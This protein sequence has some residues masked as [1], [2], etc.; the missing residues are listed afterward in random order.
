MNTRVGHSGRGA[1]TEGGETGRTGGKAKGRAQGGVRSD[2]GQRAGDT[3]RSGDREK[4]GRGA[5]RL[6]GVPSDRKRQR[7]GGVASD[8]GN[9]KEC[10]WPGRNSKKVATGFLWDPTERKIKWADGS[11]IL[12]PKAEKEAVE[13][14]KD[15][16]A[17][18]AAVDVFAGT[19]SMGPVHR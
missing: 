15:R 14:Q 13:E 8:T 6:G 3:R 19:Q 10:V 16:A 1:E 12:S 11:D 5:P 17:V 18:Q 4:R 7:K 9:E 2:R